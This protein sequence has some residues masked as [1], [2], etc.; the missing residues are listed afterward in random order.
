MPEGTILDGLRFMVVGMGVVFCFLIL[1]VWAM[2]LAASFFRKFEHLFPEPQEPAKT[3][4]MATQDDT[5]I[6]I[7]IAAVHALKG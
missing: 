5:G 2:Q 3:T 7:A 4:S 1:M 6:A